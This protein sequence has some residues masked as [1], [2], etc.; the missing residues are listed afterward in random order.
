MNIEEIFDKYHGCQTKSASAHRDPDTWN[1]CRGC[2]FEL[3]FGI[4][5][6]CRRIILFRD[7][8]N[9]WEEEYE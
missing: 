1:N 8:M 9:K 6:A 7:D 5:R 2:E 3:P 4:R